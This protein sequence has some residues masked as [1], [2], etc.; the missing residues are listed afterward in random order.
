MARELPQEPS[1]LQEMVVGRRNIGKVIGP[2][3]E[4]AAS[5]RK[6]TRCQLHVVPHVNRADDTQIVEI[7]G[8]AQQV[9][10]RR[11]H[12]NISLIEVLRNRCPA[13]GHSLV[14]AFCT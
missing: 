14:A 6:A 5:I 2:G 10:N 12:V 4:V 13:V 7:S 3:G 8:N 9:I 1:I 11:K